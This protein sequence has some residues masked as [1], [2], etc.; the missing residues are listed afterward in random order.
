MKKK[1]SKCHHKHQIVSRGSVKLLFSLVGGSVVMWSYLCG[2][3]CL[4]G[5]WPLAPQS[6]QSTVAVPL[7]SE[8]LC[9]AVCVR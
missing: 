4:S 8:W 9:V 3:T 1:C 6:L 2:L 5:D 7:M